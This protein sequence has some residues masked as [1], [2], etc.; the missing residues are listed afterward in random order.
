MQMVDS[1]NRW[2]YKGSVT[3]PPCAGFVF[4]NV[5]STIYPISEQ[6]LQLFKKQ[7]D[8]GEEGRLDEYGNWRTIQS[9]DE[10]NVIYL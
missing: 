9:E 5:L 2:M 6:H 8:R 1:N 4:W 3:T 7:L 10:H